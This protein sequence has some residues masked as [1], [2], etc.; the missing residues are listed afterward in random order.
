M[1]GVLS[2]VQNLGRA[3][4]RAYAEVSKTG[5]GPPRAFGKEVGLVPPG[6]VKRTEM[7]QFAARSNKQ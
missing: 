3:H 5:Q 6:L 2:T 4:T 7:L 1:F